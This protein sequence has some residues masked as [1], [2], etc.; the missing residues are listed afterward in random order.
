MYDYTRAFD[1]WQHAVVLAYTERECRIIATS[2]PNDYSTHL[3]RVP[4]AT[5]ALILYSMNQKS[6]GMWLFA[7]SHSTCGSVNLHI[8]S[9]ISSLLKSQGRDNYNVIVAYPDP[10]L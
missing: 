6:F 2:H 5:A 8:M 4:A 1:G 10:A 3:T 7:F 9:P